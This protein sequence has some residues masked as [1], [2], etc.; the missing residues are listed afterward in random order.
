MLTI[1]DEFTRECL[2]IDVARKLTSEDVLERLSD[3]FVRTGVPDHIR[4]DNGSEFN[5]KHFRARA[6]VR[7]AAVHDVF[8]VVLAGHQGV[9][10]RDLRRVSKPRGD[11]DGGQAHPEP[12][13]LG[14]T[15]YAGVESYRPQRYAFRPPPAAAFHRRPRRSVFSHKNVAPC[16]SSHP[17][18]PRHASFF[19]PAQPLR[20]SAL[21]TAR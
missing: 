5:G 7:P 17:P 6:Y 18:R 8:E 2:A 11:N 16:R 15:R 21:T 9:L 3:L 1:V 19:H 4:S 12:P 14:A 20:A 13:I 10:G